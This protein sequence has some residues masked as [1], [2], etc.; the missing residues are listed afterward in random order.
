MGLVSSALQIGKAALL[1]YQS[2]LQVVGN[3]VANAGVEDYARQSP[4]LSAL[5]GVTLPEGLMPG[6]GV[7]L[8]SLQRHVDT[9]LEARLRSA[10]SDEEQALIQQQ[11]LS[12]IESLY[13]ALSD[14]D[15][16][17]LL[18]E[19]FNAFEDVQNNPTDLPTRGVAISTGQ[20]VANEL[21]RMRT[22][23][24]NI[25][26]QLNEQLV[27]VTQQASQLADQ[28]A[29]L[30]V[31]IVRA[32]STG[33]GAAAAL[34]DQRDAA[35][36]ELA[37]LIDVRAVET[38]EGALNV[39]IGNEPLVEYGRSRGLTTT[40]QLVGDR[41]VVTVRFADNNGQISVSSGQVAGI[42]NARDTHTYEQIQ[43]LD[44]LAAALI[45][46]VNRL[47]S[48]GQ[49]LEGLT[50]VTGAYCVQDPDAALNA[51]GNGLPFAPSHGSFKIVV[52]N[53]SSGLSTEA[54][55]A[56]DLDGLG[57]DMSL[58]DL[59]TALTAV[60]NITATVTGDN[61]LRIQADN[62]FSFTFAEDSSGVLAS[63][64][65]NVFFTGRDARDIAVDPALADAP[66]RLAAATAG[67]PGDGTNAGRISSL[68][69]SGI[70]ALGG[71]SVLE[72][73]RS[74]VGALAVNSASVRNTT[75][76]AH[77]V[78]QALQSE[79][80]AISGVN[81]DE[82]AILLMRFQRSFQAAA[83]YISLV[84]QLVDEMLA[85]AR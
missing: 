81:L 46:Q 4:R 48:E 9:A 22:Q 59:A 23:L 67:Q 36:K 18:N 27:D 73:W 65:I 42:L 13:D 33:Q 12:R 26:D 37:R 19:F 69:D 7:A 28:I 84:D 51:A 8:T 72:Q 66:Q 71:L 41:T 85:I 44:N 79:R 25:H 54:L 5:A 56:V 57:T 1:S 49:G 21:N 20:A 2:A 34:R 29:D 35:V 63:L 53:E 77:N 38:P 55:I 50:D 70:E 47:H 31:R 64:G 43:Q 32:E 82:E 16:S 83:R 6:G 30:N 24:L 75:E 58:N 17:S 68:A 74:V 14:Q 78:S 76:A 3:N 61:R 62:G 40:E 80:E 52:T 10:L 45:E 60:D 11:T 39:F 15:L